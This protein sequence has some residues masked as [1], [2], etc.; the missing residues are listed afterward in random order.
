MTQ[1][2]YN[3]IINPVCKVCIKIGYNCKGLTIKDWCKAKDCKDWEFGYLD[4]CVAGD[5]N[6]IDYLK[7]SDIS[8]ED[9]TI[10]DNV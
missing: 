1:E 8:V 7:G 6:L 5:L 10:L 3:A 9:K 4:H 2:Q